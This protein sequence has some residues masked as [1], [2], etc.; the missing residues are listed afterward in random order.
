MRTLCTRDWLGVGRVE[1]DRAARA[2][3][4]LSFPTH[5]PSPARPSFTHYVSRDYFPTLPTPSPSNPPS[6]TPHTHPSS[7]L[8]VHV[9]LWPCRAV[10]NSPPEIE[11][12]ATSTLF[13]FVT[14]HE[15]YHTSGTSSLP[16]LPPTSPPP[17][18]TALSPTP[19][20]T[21]IA[22]SRHFRFVTFRQTSARTPLVVL[23]FPPLPRRP[24]CEMAASSALQFNHV[25]EQQAAAHYPGADAGA[26]ERAEY[27]R[28]QLMRKIL[29]K[30]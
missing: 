24:R 4:A 27:H 8:Q 23:S 5:T 17:H 30:L 6:T 2:P 22:V 28:C 11:P 13:S 25:G 21:Q 14:R 9:Y 16:Y 19:P 18:H 1:R 12:L 7:H 10:P 29:M 3:C 20:A 15:G 26:D